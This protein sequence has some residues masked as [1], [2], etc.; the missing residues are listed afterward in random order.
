MIKKAAYIL[1]VSVIS[2]SVLGCVAL[3]Q[4]MT[5]GDGQPLVKTVANDL[6]ETDKQIREV[7]W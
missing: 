2:T 6:K 5:T 4:H 7:L 3:R 1:F